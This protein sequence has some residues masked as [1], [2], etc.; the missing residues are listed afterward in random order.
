MSSLPSVTETTPRPA[1][2]LPTYFVSRL[3]IALCLTGGDVLVFL[4]S[5]ITG[6]RNSIGLP[7][8]H[9]LLIAAVIGIAL[10]LAN[11]WYKTLRCRHPTQPNSR[12]PF[13]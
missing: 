13:L 1:S 6:F 2:T 10:T 4:K 11:V 12:N 3:V 7:V 8:L 5:A 9:W